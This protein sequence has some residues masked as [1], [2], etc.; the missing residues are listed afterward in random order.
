M[1]MIIESVQIKCLP[2]GSV[3]FA[4]GA[5]SPFVYIPILGQV[6]LYAEKINRKTFNPW[7][8][9]KKSII[10]TLKEMADEE[11]GGRIEEDEV[12]GESREFSFR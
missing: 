10:K 8:H 2:L 11:S 9:E 4:Q 1:K 7:Y 6:A 5:V 12:R 3:L